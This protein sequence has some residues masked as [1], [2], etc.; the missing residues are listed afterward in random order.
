MALL[1]IHNIKKSFGGVHA[2]QGSNFSVEQGKI[3]AL[4]GPNGAGK[5]TLFN[6]I[7]GLLK[8]DSGTIIF[9]NKD[10]TKKPPHAIAN[11]GISRT[12]Q[13]VRLFH[14]LTIL[15]HLQM[16]EN[17]DDQKFCKQLLTKTNNNRKKH[18]ETID[19]FGIEKTVDTVVSDL[20]YGQRKLLNIAMALQKKHHLL[21]LDEPV[22]G[23]N[24]VIQ[25]KIETLLK[26]LKEQGETILLIDHDMNFIR[27]IADHVIALDAGVVIAEGSPKDVLNNPKVLEAYLGE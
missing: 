21:M 20:S 3:T 18:Q 5:T 15:D 14:Y 25:E 27:Q 2:I 17:N 24:S 13:Q 19:Q 26:Q 10:I 6:L 11:R 4:I 22:A 1:Q 12:F 16:V 23:V 9:Q 7:T 8:P